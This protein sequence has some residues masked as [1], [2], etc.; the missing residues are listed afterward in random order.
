MSDEI[1]NDDELFDGANHPEDE[2]LVDDD[3]EVAEPPTDDPPPPTEPPTSSGHGGIG[4]RDVLKALA[5]VPVLGA[6]GYTALR[7]KGL[8]REERQRLLA[9]LG[10]EDEGAAVFSELETRTHPEKI[11]I[12]IIGYGGEGAS[13]VRSLGFA[14]PDWIQARREAKIENPR[15]TWLDE[16]LEQENLNLELTA[17][18]DLFDLRAE[19]AIAA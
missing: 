14:H 9:E 7:R 1:R 18:C 4:R 17:V 15:D 10:I 6:L 13:L 8:A 5:T 19:A 3:G 12:G 16:W 11:R 2:Q